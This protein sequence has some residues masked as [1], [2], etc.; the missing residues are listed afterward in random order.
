MSLI[1][2]L[3]L[4]P[5]LSEYLS[6]INLEF[7]H[8]IL[9]EK[10]IVDEKTYQQANTYLDEFDTPASKTKKNFDIEKI[11]SAFL[12]YSLTLKSNKSLEISFQ[13]LMQTI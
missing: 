8:A 13:N 9:D 4:Y 6:L 2:S 5:Q 3:S 10:D 1:S 7:V 12:A 11:E